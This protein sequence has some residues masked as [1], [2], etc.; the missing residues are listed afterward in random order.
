M[1]TTLRQAFMLDNG[2]VLSIV[3]AGG[4]TSLMYRLAHELAED[5][6]SVLTTTTTKIFRPETGQ[7]AC[8]VL[9]DSVEAMLK[10][11]ESLLAQHRHITAAAGPAAMPEK[12]IGFAPEEVDLIWKSGL[13]RWIIVEADGAARLPLKAPAPHEP[14]FPTSTKEAIA[15]VGLSAVGK[16]LNDRTVFRPAIFS[17]LTGLAPEAP[18]DA[19]AVGEALLHP[20][21]LFKGCPPHAVRSV[22]LNQADIPQGIDMGRRITAAIL[23]RKR[24]DLNRIVIGQARLT[25]PVLEVRSA[26]DKGDAYGF[27]NF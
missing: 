26:I 22:F 19:E 7:S 18:I 27:R 11:G 2:G 20:Q 3:G 16:P 9:S 24:T 25:P 15:V 4:K 23:T 6:D 12:L 14:V 21:G 5:G 8:V 17:Q 1:M 13:F 10:Q